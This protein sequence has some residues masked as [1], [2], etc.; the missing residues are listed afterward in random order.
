MN[1]KTKK[2]QGI[3][4]NPAEE[5]PLFSL[6]EI[7]GTQRQI[8]SIEKNPGII[9]SGGSGYLG[10]DN[11]A[12]VSGYATD[13]AL[14]A[15]LATGC[16]VRVVR[17]KADLNRHLETVAHQVEGNERTSLIEIKGPIHKLRGIHVIPGLRLAYHRAEDLGKGKWKVTAEVDSEALEEIRTLDLSVKILLSEKEMAQRRALFF[18]EESEE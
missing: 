12:C 2:T 18:G 7:E 13:E 10:D 6:I 16:R 15:I 8:Y 11:R 3:K 1:P 4:N 9:L 17:T 5:E 14:Q